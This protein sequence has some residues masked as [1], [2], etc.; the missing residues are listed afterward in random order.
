MI[1]IEVLKKLV[2]NVLKKFLKIT[3]RKRCL[4]NEEDIAGVQVFLVRFYHGL[5]QGHKYVFDIHE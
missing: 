3:I 1:R 2:V 4:P 5:T